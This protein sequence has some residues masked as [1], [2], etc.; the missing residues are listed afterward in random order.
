MPPSEPIDFN[1]NNLD[2]ATSPYL[3]QHRENP[4]HWQLWG[5]EVLAHAEATNTPILLSVGYAACHWCHVMAHE[6][7]E[8]ETIAAQMNQ[9]FINIKIDREERPDLDAIYQAA[10]ALLGGQGGWPLTMF[11]TPKGEP[12]WGGTYFPKTAAYGRPGFGDILTALRTTYTETPERITANVEALSAAL[13]EVNAAHDPLDLPADFYLDAA[14]KLL[15]VVD[16]VHGGLQGAPKFPHTSFFNLLWISYLKTHDEKFKNPVETTLAN[17]CQGGIY[18]HVGGGFSRYSVDGQWLVPHFEK[19]LYDNAELLG[20]L[21]EVWRHDRNPLLA[22]RIGET[23]A[24]LE[25]EMLTPEGAFAASLDA[26]SEGVEGKFYV[27]SEAEVQALT[28]DDYAL[29]SNTYDITPDGN[30]EGS[31]ILNRLKTLDWQ[32]EAE[33]SRLQTMLKRLK[34]ARNER[35]RPGWDDKVLTDWNGLMI[36][37]L[38]EAALAF[39]QDNWLKTA[40]NAHDFVTKTMS[41]EGDRLFHS[42]RAGRTA[43]EG[44]AEDYAG[45]ITAALALHEATGKT[46][47]LIRAEAWI[48]TLERDFWDAKNGRLFSILGRRQRHHCQNTKCTRQSNILCQ[49]TNIEGS[50]QPLSSL[51]QDA[52]PSEGR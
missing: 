38:T 10:L 9:G 44:L 18:D 15:T 17:I 29:F 37:G 48:A 32:G 16:D 51:R 24:W 1:R 47:Y 8:A 27:W 23:I 49:R 35:I 36:A 7:F 5:P 26:D 42:Y 12:F 6:S 50:H 11:L 2:T 4:V 52:L 31:T 28:G 3:L 13:K 20:L 39:D 14:T 40:E 41:R 21:T 30:F 45:M 34:T 22:Q 25:T 19:M 46:A 33:E 43:I